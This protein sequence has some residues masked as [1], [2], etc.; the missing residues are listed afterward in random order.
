MNKAETDMRAVLAAPPSLN[1]YGFG[2]FDRKGKTTQQIEEEL[3][4]KR[5]AML[6]AESL[7]RFEKARGW[8]R[9]FEKQKRIH[10]RGTSYGLKHVAAREIGY[11]T[12]G[13]FIA[14]AIAENFTISQSGP[15]A[16][17]N[18]SPKAWS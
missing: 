10:H 16:I 13:V 5:S 18:I 15:N 2:L 11:V 17:M 12:N 14:A 4:E 1:H 7:E 3:A 8:L 9:R 6:D